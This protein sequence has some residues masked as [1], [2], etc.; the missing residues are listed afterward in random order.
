MSSARLFTAGAT[1]ASR[2][3]ANLKH[4][5]VA[6]K[7]EPRWWN[8]Q[9]KRLG[10]L[11]EDRLLN[12]GSLRLVSPGGGEISDKE[13]IDSLLEKQAYSLVHDLV[14]LNKE[15]AV[16][17]GPEDLDREMIRL[18]EKPE[19]SPLDKRTLKQIRLTLSE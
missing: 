15:V 12:T 11:F 17:Y 4:L 1:W 5:V 8:H 7:A 16:N 18:T 10:P 19:T 9:Q 14:H 6:L 2:E 3:R 13:V